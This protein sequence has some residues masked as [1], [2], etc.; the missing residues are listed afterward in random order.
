MD[1]SAFRENSVIF[2]NYHE[3]FCTKKF[4][5][6]STKIEFILIFYQ[7]IHVLLSFDCGY[8][9]ESIWLIF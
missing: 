2:R 3:F 4:A 8:M 5:L 1:F 6:E 9:Q 7:F